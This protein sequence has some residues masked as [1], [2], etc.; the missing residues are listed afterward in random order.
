M[1]A[2]FWEMR[3][4]FPRPTP[5]N[6]SPG[7]TLQWLVHHTK[8]SSHNVALTPPGRRFALH[9]HNSNRKYF[10]VGQEQKKMVQASTTTWFSCLIAAV[11]VLLARPEETAAHDLPSPDTQQQTTLEDQEKLEFREHYANIN[12]TSVGGGLE[13]VAENHDQGPGWPIP[14]NESSEAVA[15]IASD[16][17][18]RRG[19][20]TFPSIV[21]PFSFVN[22]YMSDGTG[23]RSYSEFVAQVA[24]LNEAY[25]GADARSGRYG[26]ATDTRIRFKPRR[27]PVRPE[28]RLLQLLRPAELHRQDETKVHDGRAAVHL[29]VWVCWCQNN[30]G[31]AWLPY[32]TWFRQPTG[33]DHYALGAIVHHE[34][35]PG[36]SFHGG[37]W[38][39]GKMLVHEVGHGESPCARHMRAQTLT[40]GTQSMDSNIPTK[41]T[42]M[43]PSP[44]LTQSTT[45]PG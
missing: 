20:S 28:Q 17:Q 15:S 7:G 25:S 27:H 36:N 4:L 31:L 18:Q 29:N 24:Q 14:G 33:E 42:A 45:P 30:L 32:D 5:M 43:V 41:G 34:L 38:S 2:K 6:M 11:V 21:Q 35:L 37:L 23:K 9:A 22:F 10:I 19:R 26:S 13:F 16:S 39:Q 44:T 3:K 12:M 1:S 8:H 40:H